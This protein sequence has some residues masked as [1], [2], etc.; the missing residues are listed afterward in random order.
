M[1]GGRKCFSMYGG[2]QD[3]QRGKYGVAGLFVTGDSCPV[4]RRRSKSNWWISLYYING[5]GSLPG[6]RSVL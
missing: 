4:A 3:K 1:G 5:G 2:C 6:G